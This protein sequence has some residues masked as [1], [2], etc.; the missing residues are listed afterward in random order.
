MRALFRIGM[1][2][3]CGVLLRYNVLLPLHSR[4]SLGIYAIK[5]VTIFLFSQVAE[6][7]QNKHELSG[8]LAASEWQIG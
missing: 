5:R 7:R 8:Q 2:L 1:V 6:P 4:A 3:R